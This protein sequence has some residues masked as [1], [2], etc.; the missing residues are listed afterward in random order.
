MGT[1]TCRNS[2]IHVKINTFP[3]FKV[4]S[5]EDTADFKTDSFQFYLS[6]VPHFSLSLAL[7]IT[8]FSLSSSTPD[9]VYFRLFIMCLCSA[10][11][12]ECNVTEDKGYEF[13]IRVVCLVGDNEHI[14][15]NIR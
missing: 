10:F 5:L 6:V 12:L 7:F 8:Y 13:F 11:G 15:L 1:Q 14:A 3:A 9:I 2:H 4:L